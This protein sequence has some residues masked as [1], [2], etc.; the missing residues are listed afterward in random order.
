MRAIGEMSIPLGTHVLQYNKFRWLSRMS[1]DPLVEVTVISFYITGNLE[2]VFPAEYQKEIMPYLYPHQNEDGGWG[3]H[4]EWHSIKCCT[5]LSYICMRLLGEGP[6]GGLNGACTKERKY[7]PDH[8]SV[9]SIP[10]LGKTCLSESCNKNVYEPPQ[11]SAS[12]KNLLHI[13]LQLNSSG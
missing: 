9:T 11:N 5:T 8:G 2:I 1:G 6:D 13:I 4:I 7:I 10:S 12:C 3:F